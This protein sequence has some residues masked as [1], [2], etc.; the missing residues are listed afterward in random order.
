MSASNKMNNHSATVT[1]TEIHAGT[2]G[3]RFF[4]VCKSQHS[5]SAKH[6]TP[7][8]GW[9]NIGLHCREDQVRLNTHEHLEQDVEV[10][11]IVIHGTE[12]KTKPSV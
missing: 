4:P 12:T 8:H 7:E 2:D 1:E 3:S 11:D 10:E 5:I 9:T 6:Q